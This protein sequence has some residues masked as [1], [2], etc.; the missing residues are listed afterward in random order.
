MKIDHCEISQIV[1]QLCKTGDW[2]LNLRADQ[3]RRPPAGEPAEYNPRLHI[4]RN[5]FVIALRCLGNS[6]TRPS[7]PGAGRPVLAVLKPRP[8][9]VQNGQPRHLRVSGHD[10]L[11]GKHFGDIDRVQIEFYYH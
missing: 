3:N 7:E 9:W 11:I 5:Q 6:L 8:F 4:K 2:A 10:D 1:L